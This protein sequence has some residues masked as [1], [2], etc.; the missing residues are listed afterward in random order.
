MKTF[1]LFKLVLIR[2]FHNV[3]GIPIKL[4]IRPVP[5]FNKCCNFSW[6]PIFFFLI[7]YKIATI[8]SKLREL[9][10]L[11][12]ITVINMIITLF[13]RRSHC[14]FGLFYSLVNVEKCKMDFFVQFCGFRFLNFKFQNWSK[15]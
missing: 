1:Q 14:S 12:Y 7:M 3:V 10:S 9:N 2:L 4:Q 15:N 11:T 8:A 5:P 6:Y 13:R